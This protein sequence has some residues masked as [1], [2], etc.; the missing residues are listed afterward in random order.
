[1]PARTNFDSL[2]DAMAALGVPIESRALARALTPDVPSEI[3]MPAKS[4]YIAVRPLGERVV[5]TYVNRTYIDQ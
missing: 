4:P 3:W 2:D 5:E 1:M